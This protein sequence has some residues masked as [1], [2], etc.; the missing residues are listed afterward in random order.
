MAASNPIKP[1]DQKPLTVDEYHESLLTQLEKEPSSAD[2][3]ADAKSP[4]GKKGKLI[5]GEDV[6]N[7]LTQSI[8]QTELKSQIK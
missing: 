2:K 1:E 6:Y 7:Y 5:E 4:D 8:N 3:N